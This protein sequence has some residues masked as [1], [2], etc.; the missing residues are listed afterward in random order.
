MVAR[1]ANFLR[2]LCA[3]RVFELKHIPGSVNI[4]D[5]LTK[6]VTLAVFV[7][8]MKILH[9]LSQESTAMLVK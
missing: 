1:A 4:A 3:R 6:G 9:N 8:L 7:K 5:I 2:D